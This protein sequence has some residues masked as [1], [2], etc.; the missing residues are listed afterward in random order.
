MWITKLYIIALLLIGC[1]IFVGSVLAIDW[2]AT[3][4]EERKSRKAKLNLKHTKS[5]KEKKNCIE[6]AENP[7]MYTEAELVSFGN[8]LLEQVYSGKRVAKIVDPKLV[9][10]VGDWDLAN[11]KDSLK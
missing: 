5:M 1:A 6:H 10:V 2:I 11:W 7:K 4:L 8:Y 9:K 3:K